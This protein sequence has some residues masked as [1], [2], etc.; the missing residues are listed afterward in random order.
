M[1]IRDST[2][3]EQKIF[4]MFWAAEEDSI[5]QTQ[6]LRQS[7]RDKNDAWQQAVLAADR[8][9]S[10]PWEMYCFIH[11]LPTRH[12]GS[13]LPKTGTPTCGKKRCEQLPKLWDTLWD[14]SRGQ[15]WE[16]RKIWNAMSARQSAS[17]GAV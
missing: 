17:V 5:Q 9:G 15:D 4:R 14:R 6:V 2:F 3:E 12:A 11:G 10:E 16:L 13:W 7:M 1:C 8:T